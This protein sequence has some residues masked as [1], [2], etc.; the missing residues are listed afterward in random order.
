MNGGVFEFHPEGFDNY[1][2]HFMQYLT[3][4]KETL[5]HR[6]RNTQSIV[7]TLTRTHTH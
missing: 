3:L 5:C 7:Q 2:L 1:S 4:V 6:F